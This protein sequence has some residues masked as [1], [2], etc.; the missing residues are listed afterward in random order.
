MA[1]ITLSPEEARE[2][3]WEEHKDWKKIEESITGQRRWVTEM[4]G[5]FHHLPTNKY[6]EFNWEVG[7]TEVQECRPYEDNTEVEAVEVIQKEVV[8]KEWVYV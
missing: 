5:I 3:I 8:K 6:Y 1:K 4:S 7:S 2:I